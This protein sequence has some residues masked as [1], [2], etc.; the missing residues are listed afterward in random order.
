MEGRGV[1]PD[2][3]FIERLWKSVRYGVVYLHAYD[4]MAEARQGLARPFSFYNKGRS[5]VALDGQTP[6]M[7]YFAP[8][9][10]HEAA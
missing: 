4:S 3:P 5:H 7:V 9:P 8:R 1:W 10:Q 2:N 6:D